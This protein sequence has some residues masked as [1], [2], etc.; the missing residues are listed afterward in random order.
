MVVYLLNE[1]G[2]ETCLR[3]SLAIDFPEY[4]PLQ[5]SEKDIEDNLAIREMEETLWNSIESS[6][7]EAL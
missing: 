1:H 2:L 4:T 6:S 7:I 3:P 5:N